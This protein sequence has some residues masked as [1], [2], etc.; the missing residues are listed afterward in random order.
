VP[1]AT[2]AYERAMKALEDLDYTR[3]EDLLAEALKADPTY[4]SAHLEVTLLESHRC[5]ADLPLMRE[6]LASAQRARATL[7]D[8]ER[9]VL[10]AI[11]PAV[12]D[13]PNLVEVARRFRALS[14]RRPLDVPLLDELGVTE[15]KLF[16]FDASAA[17]YQRALALEPR[18]DATIFAQDL[19]SVEQRNAVLDHCVGV[20]GARLDC[21][22]QQ[23]VDDWIEGSC[24][25]LEQV[26]RDMAALAPDQPRPHRWLAWALAG[27]GAPVEAIEAALARKRALAPGGV[28]RTAE[29][30]DAADIALWTGDFATA[31][32]DL[33]ELLASAR[34][35][36]LPG[37]AL[38]RVETLWEIGD[39]KGAGQAALSYVK[40][41]AALPRD[42]RPDSDVYPL[43]LAR[44]RQGGSLEEREYMQ[45]RDAWVAQ[46]RAR[47]D[48]VAWAAAGPIVWARAFAHAEGDEARRA[49]A[50]AP[51]FAGFPPARSIRFFY[52]DDGVPGETLRHA[53]RLDDALPRLESAAA[54]CDYGMS[55]VRATLALGE[56]LEERRDTAGACKAY[57]FVLGRW[58]AARPRSVTAEQAKAHA[59][60][61]GC[62]R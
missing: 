49:V 41:A 46:W 2:E 3:C 38:K 32:R 29:L 36:A 62:D 56:V 11:A 40:R 8:R 9:D 13:P 20:P 55:R 45:K 33:D 16:H 42:E 6:H 1:A 44:A 58:G 24:G 4:P 26:S 37:L 23:A 21:R 7:N 15:N 57:A 22:A 30:G 47:V 27:Q 18:M 17:A 54:K 31:L 60:R 34:D 48:A 5:P 51:D 59:A 12:L 52:A 19:A 14:E 43:F 25:H 39:R 50:R 61:L 10:D 28:T 53:G 35:A